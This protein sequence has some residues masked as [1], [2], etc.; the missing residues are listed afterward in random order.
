MPEEGGRNGEGLVCS[1]PVKFWNQA[2][3]AVRAEKSAVVY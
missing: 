2:G 1:V 3:H